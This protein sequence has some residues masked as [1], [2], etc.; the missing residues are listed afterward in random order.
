MIQFHRFPASIR[1]AEVTL[2]RSAVVVADGVAR[3]AD[4]QARIVAERDDFS[5]VDRRGNTVSLI[6][7]DGTAWKIGPGDGCGC[8]GSLQRW[9]R[10]Q[11]ARPVS[12]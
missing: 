2:R 7:A 11:L 9:Y 4:A 10:G 5:H 8:K 6:F 12:A 1:S 3:V